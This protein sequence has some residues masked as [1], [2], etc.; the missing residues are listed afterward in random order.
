MMGIC[1]KEKQLNVVQSGVILEKNLLLT[2]NWFTG[3]DCG[4]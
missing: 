1:K 4:L 3:L 2:R